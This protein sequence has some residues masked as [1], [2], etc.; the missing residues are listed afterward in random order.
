VV[1]LIVGK[2]VTAWM[3]S[4]SDLRWSREGN[5]VPAPFIYGAEY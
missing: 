1:S 4:A 3:Q 2:R 5:F